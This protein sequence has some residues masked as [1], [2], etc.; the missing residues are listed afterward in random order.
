MSDVHNE[1]YC[2]CVVVTCL[3]TPDQSVEVLSCSREFG[4]MEVVRVITIILAIVNHA[5]CQNPEGRSDLN[6]FHVH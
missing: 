6:L 5:R 1:V 4:T 2:D 3:R